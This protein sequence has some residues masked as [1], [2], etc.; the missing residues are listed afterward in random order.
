MRDRSVAAST[1]VINSTPNQKTYAVQPSIQYISDSVVAI[2]S[3]ISEAVRNGPGNGNG[4]SGA[5]NLSYLTT[6]SVPAKGGQFKVIQ[7]APRVAPYNRHAEAFGLQYGADGASMP[8]VGAISGASTGMSQGLLQVI[9]INAD[10]TFTAEPDPLK[11]YEVSKYSDVAGLPAMTK[12]DPDQARGFIHAYYGVA[13]PGYRVS[14]GFMP[15]VKTFS[16]SAVA[17]YTNPSTD[18]RESLTFALVPAT[19]DPNVAT[20]PG[21]ATPNVPPGPS[22]TAPTGTPVTNPTAPSTGSGASST[23]STTSGTSSGS[24]GSGDTGSSG[25][26]GSPGYHAPGY[27]GGGA[28]A[29]SGCGC[30][31]AG[32]DQTS[33]LGGFAAL[34][35]GFAL[36]GLRRRSTSKKELVR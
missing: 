4:H 16:I 6:L 15:E 23:G 5:P 28:T 12:R 18:N 29:S 11:L 21:S 33:G 32:S 27:T 20:T 3:Q 10:G 22:P 25:G 26:T 31:T 35:L 9:P 24:T 30:T 13:N 19:W 1:H 34:G 2:E 7:T 17:G 8:A 14:T 36:F